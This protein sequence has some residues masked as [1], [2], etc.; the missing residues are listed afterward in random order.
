MRGWIYDAGR[1]LGVTL[2]AAN[3]AAW[4]FAMWVPTGGLSLGGADLVVGFLMCLAAIVAVMAAAR[5]HSRV[6]FGAFLVAFLPVGA[7]VMTLDHWL[8]WTGWADLG[9]L[10]SAAVLRY[11]SPGANEQLHEE[12]SHS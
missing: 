12:S 8:R 2:G 1:G 3:A 7:F 10:V 4:A 6:L 11:T 5:G 9:L